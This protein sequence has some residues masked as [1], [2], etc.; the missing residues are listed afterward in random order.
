MG[1][2]VMVSIKTVLIICIC[3]TPILLAVEFILMHYVE[4]RRWQDFKNP[5]SADQDPIFKQNKLP[6]HDVGYP[7]GIFDPLALSNGDL[8]ELKEK[9]IKNG[10]LAMVAFVGFIVQEQVNGLNPLSAL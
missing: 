3:S 1:K 4:I 10:R 5:G 7:G 6:K 9:E 2:K 8:K